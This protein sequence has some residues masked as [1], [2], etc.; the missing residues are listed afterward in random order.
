MIN[1]LN[2][3]NTPTKEEI[4]AAI[5]AGICMAMPSSDQVL[6]AIRDELANRLKWDLPEVAGTAIEYAV[7]DHLAAKGLP[8][9]RR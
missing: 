6:T 2:E 5:T 8:R 4:L 1:Y 9:T 3:S 7:K